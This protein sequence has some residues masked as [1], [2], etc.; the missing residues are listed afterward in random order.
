VFLQLVTCILEPSVTAALWLV[1]HALRATLQP[2]SQVR[3]HVFALHAVPTI[4]SLLLHP[5][6]AYAYF[7]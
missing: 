4:L 1:L 7:G 3:M 5:I 2:S 6:I